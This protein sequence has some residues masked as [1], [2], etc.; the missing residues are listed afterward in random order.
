M[1]K[2]DNKRIFEVIAK[3]KPRSV[4][5]N[6]PEALIPKIQDTANDISE[7]FGIPAYVIGDTCWGS[8]DL[9]THAADMLGAEILFNIGHTVVME[10][11]GEKVVMIDAYD[12]SNFE[13][14]ARKC[15]LGLRD[16]N[17]KS[18]SLLTNSQHLYQIPYVKKNFE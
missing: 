8:C 11:F 10:T 7:Q 17:Y 16:Q 2:I 1:L 18:I 6:G 13:E 15:A 5:L 12:D 3:R 14:V 9:N 4:A